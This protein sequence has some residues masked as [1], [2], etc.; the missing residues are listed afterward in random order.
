MCS[1]ASASPHV[2]RVDAEARRLADPVGER[3]VEHLHVHLSDIAPH[4]LLE[5]VD[6]EASVLVGGHRAAR[7]ALALLGV[8][9]PVAPR[10]PRHGAV[11]LRLGDALD[12]RDE[13]DEA[14]VALVAEEAVHVAAAPG[15][16]RVDR[17]ER[18]PLDTGLPEVSEAGHHLVERP[19]AALV[20]AVRV[21]QLAR[22][23]DRDPDQDL[24]LAEERRPLL[25]EQGRVRLDRVQCALA[26][27]EVLRRQLDRPAEEVEA[28]QRGLAPLPG[29][30]HLGNARVGLDQLADVRLE[31]VVGHAE[32][33]PGVEHLLREEEAVRAVEVADGAGGLGKQVERRRGARER[34]S[35]HAGSVAGV[36]RAASSRSDDRPA[37]PAAYRRRWMVVP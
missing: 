1:R 5:D 14:G 15:V 32:A 36:A 35:L 19:L 20:H 6:Q 22:A 31:Q 29:D 3:D 24:V 26:G 13:L 17:R 16:R 7:D 10:R 33:R 9:R 34:R 21:V 2:S 12:D 28:H 37:P 18:V 25:V 23:V 11:L 8:E 30:H 27:L 4:P